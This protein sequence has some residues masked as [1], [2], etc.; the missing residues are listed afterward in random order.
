VTVAQIVERERGRL[1][2]ANVVAGLAVAVAATST[3]VVLGV[4]ALGKSRWLAL[5]RA[6]P[7]AVWLAL[8]AVNVLV[9]RWAWRLVGAA[10]RGRVAAEIE[11]EQA[12]RAGSLR[13]VIEVADSG[14]L[15]RH[16]AGGMAHRLGA[17]GPRLAPGA[18]TGTRI[19]WWPAR[20]ARARGRC[21]PPCEPPACPAYQGRLSRRRV[22]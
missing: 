9:A 2:R 3:V 18:C 5:P 22:R 17:G 20:L 4:L 11:R 16:A 10:A 21:A 6:A 1:R 14:A 7:F 12:M 15:G 13:A 19:C 8:V